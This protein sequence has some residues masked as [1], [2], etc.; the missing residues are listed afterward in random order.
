[1]EVDLLRCSRCGLTWV[2]KTEIFPGKCPA[3]FKDFSMP[4]EIIVHGVA[5]PVRSVI[6]LG[7]RAGLLDPKVRRGLAGL[8][9]GDRC[10]CGYIS[11]IICPKCRLI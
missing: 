3:C 7:S 8:R 11:R 4:T 1:M 9:L 10:P 6:E 5:I 2:P